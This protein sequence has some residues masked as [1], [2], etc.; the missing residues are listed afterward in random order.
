MK[1]EMWM[2]AELGDCRGAADGGEAAFVPVVEDG[3][4]SESPPSRRSRK[5]GTP[6]AECCGFQFFANQFGDEAALLH[7][8]RRDAGE[9]FAVLIFQRRRDRRS[10][11]LQDDREG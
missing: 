4:E 7:C 3:R 6:G 2:L 1:P 11:R 10:R 5:V 8:Y 9:H